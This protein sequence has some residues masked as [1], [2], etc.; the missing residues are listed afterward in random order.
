MKQ[1]VTTRRRALRGLVLGAAVLAGMLGT[2]SPA[3]A[4]ILYTC[5]RWGTYTQGEWTIYNNVWGNRRKGTQCLT[6][7]SINSWYVDSKQSNGGVKSYP[8]T[9]VNPRVP[10]AQMKTAT[11]TYNTTSAPTTSGDWW[12]WSTDIWSANGADE[13]MVFTSYY[14]SAGGW[15]TKILT[16]VTIGGI[17][18]KEVWQANPGWN[19]L[20]LIPASQS[21]SGTINALAVW[22]DLAA[23]GLLTNTVFDTMQFGIEITS[24]SG[25]WKRYSLNNYNASYSTTTGGGSGI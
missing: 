4:Q 5:D 3:Q 9:S 21:N 1:G 20:Q 17:Q 16:N 12:N 13:I 7:N 11:L 2:A 19:V 10:L 25:V 24:T 8:N 6:V 22:Q 18:F 14:P 23:R 15:G